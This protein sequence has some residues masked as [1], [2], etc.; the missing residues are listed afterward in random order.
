MVDNSSRGPV[1]VESAFGQLGE[2]FGHGVHP[3]IHLHVGNSQKVGSVSSEMSV[4]KMIH[5]SHLRDYVDQ[6][7]ELTEDELA[8]IGIMFSHRLLEKFDHHEPT[9]NHNQLTII[10]FRELSGFFIHDTF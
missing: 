10:C 7:E 6:V 4:K 1:S 3:L 2:Y 5:K 8:S 9:V